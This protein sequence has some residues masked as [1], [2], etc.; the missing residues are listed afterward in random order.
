MLIEIPFGIDGFDQL[1]D[2]STGLEE[3]YFYDCTVK[4]SKLVIRTANCHL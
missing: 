1:I 2:N 3:V 4:W